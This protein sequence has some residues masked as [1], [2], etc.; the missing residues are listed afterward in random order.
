MQIQKEIEDIYV[1]K[2]L[3]RSL[4]GLNFLK[5]INAGGSFL[6]FISREDAGGLSREYVTGIPSVS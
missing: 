2:S 6:T 1:A 4:F 3:G 5:G